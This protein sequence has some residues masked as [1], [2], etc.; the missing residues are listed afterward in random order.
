MAN[1]EVR[2]IEVQFTS[3][4]AEK[5]RRQIEAFG[6]LTS[7]TEKVMAQFGHSINVTDRQISRAQ[8]RIRAITRDQDRLNRAVNVGYKQSNKY[9]K[10]GFSGSVGTMA[11]PW[12]G[13]IRRGEGFYAGAGIRPF[14]I[15]KSET[16]KLS[17]PEML[18]RLKEM[19]KKSYAGMMRGVAKPE[20]INPMLGVRWGKDAH[21]I[22]AKTSMFA[23]NIKTATMERAENA[24]DAKVEKAKS[25]EDAKTTKAKKDE[26]VA[27]ERLARAKEKEASVAEKKAREANRRIGE[28]QQRDYFARAK[29]NMAKHKANVKSRKAAI[30][31]FEKSPAQII[32]GIGSFRNNIGS[33][34]TVATQAVGE[35]TMFA[36][37][38]SMVGFMGAS[39]FQRLMSVG[40]AFA[41]VEKDFL[42][43]SAFR[44]S[45]VRSGGI[46]AGESFDKAN[47]L[48]RQYSGMTKAQSGAQLSRASTMI[49]EL[50]GNVTGSNMANLVTA[51]HGASAITGE[52]SEKMIGKVLD[53]AKKGKGA[54]KL[55]IAELKLTRNMDTNL[56]II[57]E[58]IRKDP[59]AGAILRRGTVESAMAGIRNTP[60]ELI[61][62]VFGRHQNQVSEAFQGV[63]KNLSG[64]MNDNE[65]ITKWSRALTNLTNVLDRVLTKDKLT[66]GALGAAEWG[67]E[68]AEI[69]GKAMEFSLWFLKNSDTILTGLRNIGVIWAGVQA[70]KVGAGVLNTLKDLDDFVIGISNLVNGINA[71]GT[72]GV[73]ASALKFTSRWAPFAL[74][75]GIAYGAKK[76]H[77]AYSIN[78][79]LAKKYTEDPRWLDM[80]AEKGNFIDTYKF[81]ENEEIMNT[82]LMNRAKSQANLETN[83]QSGNTFNPNQQVILL[84]GNLTIGSEVDKAEGYLQS[85]FGI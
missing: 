51:I 79:S 29:S 52:D 55:G 4:G 14:G 58:A 7:K 15:V 68:L 27:S 23:T 33:L 66:S 59:I 43:T 42:T 35:L 84:Q 54:E 18:E 22:N 40:D 28:R 19:R 11:R 20:G 12:A 69:A 36:G 44:D 8:G 65:V 62:N 61:E 85:N 71:L 64:A 45:L 41:S 60:K 32:K 34:A 49:R 30:E 6:R 1:K 17:K 10:S 75:G 50:S 74:A 73:L 16:A 26:A 13:Y 72:S 77:E 80:M 81:F 21:S 78:Q 48:N 76:T 56:E 5:T 53:I 82:P 31:S 83:F 67:A 37:A 47:E 39:A 46:R 25:I 63:Y 3:V 57:A 9:V 2:E 70:I 24:H 38:I